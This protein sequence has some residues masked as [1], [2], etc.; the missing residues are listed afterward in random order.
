MDSRSPLGRE[1]IGLESPPPRCLCR[2]V[3]GRGGEGPRPGDSSDP[4]DTDPSNPHWLNSSGTRWSGWS[5]CYWSQTCTSIQL[6]TR[7]KSF[8]L[9]QTDEKFWNL[10]HWINTIMRCFLFYLSSY[11][12]A[13]VLQ[14]VF[15][16][17]WGGIFSTRLK[18]NRPLFCSVVCFGTWHW[19]FMSW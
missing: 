3:L 12:S 2:C 6:D 14:S 10:L 8:H 9:Y 16:S 7:W 11:A 15:N 17:F 13:I 5:G 1:H 18:V 4:W 19:F